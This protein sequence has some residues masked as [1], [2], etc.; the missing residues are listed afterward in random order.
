MTPRQWAEAKTLYESGEMGAQALAARYGKDL[1]TIVKHFRKH[2]IKAGTSKKEIGALVEEEVKKRMAI[3][4]TVLAVRIKETK[5]EHY[6]MATAIGKLVFKEIVEAK[7]DGHAISTRVN[8][9][10]ALDVAMTTLKKARE[11]RYAVL[12][13]DRDDFVASEDLPELVISELTAEQ[14]EKMRATDLDADDAVA[15]A[16][17]KDAELQDDENTLVSEA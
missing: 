3:D 2:N 11:E 1:S 4:A 14:I 16:D 5:E 17:S 9:L 6:K 8:N 7:N 10:K 15:L 13:L 12:G